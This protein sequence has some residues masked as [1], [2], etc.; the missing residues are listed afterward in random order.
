MTRLTIPNAGKQPQRTGTVLVIEDEPEV[1]DLL[2]IFLKAE[3]HLTI[4][5]ADG[6]AALAIFEQSALRPDLVLADYNLPGGMDGLQIT[7][8]KEERPMAAPTCM[9]PMCLCY[10]WAGKFPMVLVTNAQKP[11]I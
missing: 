2:E 5:A 7:A 4:T 3:G 10:G 9:I 1:R 6:A 8:S 11:P